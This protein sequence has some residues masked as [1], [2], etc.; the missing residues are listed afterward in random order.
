MHV[1]SVPIAFSRWVR[2]TLLLAVF[3]GGAVG[4][5]CHAAEPMRVAFINPDKVGNAFWDAA[6]SFMQ[7]AATSLDVK[8]DVYYANTDRNGVI[9]IAEK[10]VKGPQKPDYLVFVYQVGAGSQVL[11]AAESAGVRTFIF[12]TDVPPGDE[13]LAGMPRQ[14]FPG[15]IGHMVPD[16]VLAGQNLATEL[17]EQAKLDGLRDSAGKTHILGLSGS[18][19]SSAA[20]DRSKGFDQALSLDPKA[21]VSQ[22]VFAGWDT[23]RMA[24][25]AIGLFNRNSGTHVIWAASDGI[26]LAAAD[27][28]QRIG[29]TPGKDILIGGVD[30]S[31]PGLRAIKAG[32]LSAS[33][34]GHFMDGGWSMVLLYD[35]HNGADFAGV[36]GTRIRSQLQAITSKNVDAYLKQFSGGRLET[37]DFRRFSRALNPKKKSYDFG[38]KAVLDAAKR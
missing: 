8:L 32:T 28:M 12:N 19:D 7:A 27:G 14:K 4:S 30:W 26:A 5:L 36:T 24:E 15:W 6:T 20:I 33:M 29:K 13:K 17:L 31:E 2:A 37:I 22:L 10:L 16:D 34:G 18:R 1:L 21:K 25:R 11:A 23:E 35:H 9:D 38:V 3:L